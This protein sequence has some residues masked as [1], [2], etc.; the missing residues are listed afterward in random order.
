MNTTMLIARGGETFAEVMESVNILP[1]STIILSEPHI[2]TEIV[3]FQVDTSLGENGAP[4][5][6]IFALVRITP[7]DSGDNVTRITAAHMMAEEPADA[8]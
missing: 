6:H 1:G 4:Y 5:F 7:Y 8:Q 3:N 2:I